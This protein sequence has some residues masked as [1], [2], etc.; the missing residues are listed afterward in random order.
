MPTTKYLGLGRGIEFDA[1][2]TVASSTTS[3]AIEVSLLTDDG[4]GTLLQRDE[5]LNALKVIEGH[6]SVCSWPP[7]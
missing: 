1:K 2:P 6:L 7:A 3:L 5:A 4:A